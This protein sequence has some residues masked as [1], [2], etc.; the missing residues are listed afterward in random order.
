MDDVC[1]AC[2]KLYHSRQRLIE[3]LKFVP[4]CL[5]ILQ[6]C[7]PALADETVQELDQIDHAH[8]LAMR[9]Q[10]WWATKALKPVQRISGPLLPPAN[11]P[12]ALVM[13]NRW[14]S[15]QPQRGSA[16]ENLQGR[17]TDDINEEPQVILFEADLP[18]FVL[19]SNAGPNK[20]D[21][22]YAATG[23]A[24]EFAR[25][26][27][28]TLVFVHVFSGYRRQSDL[29]QLL[30]H[31]IW[32]RIHFFVISIDMCLQKIEGNLAS[33]K[34]FQFWMHQIGT[35]QICGMGGG[36]P[37]ETDTAARMLEGGPPPLRS[38]A[39]PQ[40]FPHL[41]LR[42]WQ[43]C[44][45]GSRL[46]RF[47]LEALLGLAKT[48]GTGFMEHPQFPLWA[49]MKNPAS[50]WRC[51]AV[52]LLRTL[53][54]VGITSFDQC[55]MGSVAVKPTTILHLRL[56]RFRQIALTGGHGGRCHHGSGAHER[57]AG[58]D[59][60]GDFKTAR[61][62]IY[63][64]G[65]NHALAQAINSYVRCTFGD[66]DTTPVLPDSF[67]PFLVDDFAP[68]GIVQPDYHG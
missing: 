15:R 53:E 46:I 6:A 35:G 24:R 27:I 4:S 32:G 17:R 10:G 44:L 39:W 28:K 7:F 51:R 31:Q 18:A 62:K 40:G 63:P 30:E 22:Q 11:H 50:V 25:L 8:T 47:L 13:P 42:Q 65:L 41:R 54:C 29:H 58:R 37:C 36:P 9:Q 45:I 33:S 2:G 20:G 34:A 43:Q 12:E 48:G 3:H 61:A 21:G 19:Q 26:H 57:M 68:I 14:A 66:V 49:A 23:L 55:T 52:R 59:E 5:A 1:N 60:S 64:E 38:G 67:A 56:P 16:F